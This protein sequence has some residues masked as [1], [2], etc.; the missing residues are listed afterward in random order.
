[1]YDRLW[2]SA[3]LFFCFLGR[4]VIKLRDILINKLLPFFLFDYQ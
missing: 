3:E 1:M 2:I 4:M